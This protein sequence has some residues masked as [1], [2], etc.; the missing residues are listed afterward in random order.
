MLATL[1]FPSAAMEDFNRGAY[2]TSAAVLGLTTIVTTS[3]ATEYLNPG[4]SARAAKI[5]E[6]LVRV[7]HLPGSI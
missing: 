1:I 3:T 2:I 7:L 4:A 5:I 6:P